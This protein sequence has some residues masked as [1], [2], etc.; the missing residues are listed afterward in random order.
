MVR[1]LTSNFG[2]GEIIADYLY[3]TIEDGT[4][5]GMYKI[6][7]YGDAK[8]LLGDI[9]AFTGVSSTFTVG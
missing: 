8:S 4:P 3:R 6:T 7:Y 1:F 5:A 9:S 2:R